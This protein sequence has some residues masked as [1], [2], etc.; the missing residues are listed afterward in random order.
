MTNEVP[1]LEALRARFSGSTTL[2]FAPGPS[3]PEL[4]RGRSSWHPK[5][6][7]NDA[8][9]DWRKDGL[10][11]IVPGADIVYSSDTRWFDER[12]GLPDFQGIKVTCLGLKGPPRAPD[13]VCLKTSPFGSTGYDPRLGRICPGMNSGCAAVHL[14]AQLGA[15]LIALIG[16]DFH[17]RKGLHYFGRYSVGYQGRRPDPDFP[18]WTETFKLLADALREHGVEIVNCTPGSALPEQW[19][20][21][22]PLDAVLERK[23]A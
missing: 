18:T 23:A 17:A 2:V 21:Q 11:V 12:K 4:W 20:P 15:I 10:G 16:F 3:L 1:R 9:R 5:I 8:W 13:V 19:F 7:I 14:A 6:C 22:V